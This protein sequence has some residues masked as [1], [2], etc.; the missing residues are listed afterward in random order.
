MEKR[1][2]M[3]SLREFASATSRLY[4]VDC[5]FQCTRP[6]L[7]SDSDVALSAFRIAQE[8][9]HN[10][11]K[12]GKPKRVIIGLR[13][14]RQL[15]EL[16]VANDGASFQPQATERKRGMGLQ[17]MRYRVNLIHGKLTI[18]AKRPRGTLVKC[19]FNQYAQYDH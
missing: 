9:V 15:A 13:P 3:H 18:E 16:T 10:A 5:I 1:G 17:I 19:I 8:A 14:V 11:I 4:K 2:L 12:H 7:I 6:V